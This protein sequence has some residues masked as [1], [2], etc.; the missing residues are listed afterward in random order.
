MPRKKTTHNI[1]TVTF[2]Q[3]WIAGTPTRVIAETLRISADRCD[4]TRRQLGL[5][6]R[7]SWHGSKCGHRKPYLPTEEEIRQRCS[8]FQSSWSE[9]ERE[10]RRG[11]GGPAPV[12]IRII[13]ESSLRV[14]AE[15]GLTVEGLIDTSGD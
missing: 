4:L 10:R 9:E 1:C 14:S 11:G 7:E 3:M 5:P 13:N 6:K 8:E 15:D 2:S 12:E